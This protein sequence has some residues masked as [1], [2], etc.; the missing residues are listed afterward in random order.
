MSENGRNDI[1][2]GICL[3]V[4]ACGSKLFQTV[5]QYAADTSNDKVTILSPSVDCQVNKT[6][7]IE[8]QESPE[9]VYGEDVSPYNHPDITGTVVHIGWHFKR[10]CCF[11]KIK[12]GKKIKSRRYFENELISGEGAGKAEGR[13]LVFFHDGDLPLPGILY[14]LTSPL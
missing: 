3:D 7:I 5:V 13:D 2:W 9:Y 6:D 1:Q 10:N 4:E 12:I 8:L 11:Y 14:K